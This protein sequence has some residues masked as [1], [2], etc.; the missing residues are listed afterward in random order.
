MSELTEMT[1][2]EARE[3]Y[4][5]ELERLRADVKPLLKALQEYSKLTQP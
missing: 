3:F 4:K 2:A 5:E 1:D